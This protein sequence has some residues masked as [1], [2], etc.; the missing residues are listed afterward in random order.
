MNARTFLVTGAGKAETFNRV[1]AAEN[2]PAGA[3]RPVDGS[4]L[5]LTDSSALSIQPQTRSES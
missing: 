2:L 1:R 3:V 4:V 5:W